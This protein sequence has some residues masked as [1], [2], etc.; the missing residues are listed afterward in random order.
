[1]QSKGSGGSGSSWRNRN[2]PLLRWSTLLQILQRTSLPV[3]K[4]RARS[5]IKFYI[6]QT[7]M[8][9]AISVRSES[10]TEGVIHIMHLMRSMESRPL[11]SL[12]VPLISRSLT[13]ESGSSTQTEKEGLQ[14]SQKPCAVDPHISGP[15]LSGDLDY[16]DC[17]HMRLC[18]VMSHYKVSS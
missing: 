7:Q 9:V 3:W 13:Q 18:Y 6:L 14:S 17:M 15:Q 11:G 5:P 12:M 1:M 2:W 4:M 16:P 8:M 10:M